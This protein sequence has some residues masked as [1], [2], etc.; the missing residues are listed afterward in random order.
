M[1]A[2]TPATALLIE[3]DIPFTLHEYE[4]EPLSG[5]Q[6]HRGERIAYGDAAASALGISPDRLYKTLVLAIEGAKD[7]RL[8]FA[9]AVVPSSGELSEKGV[10][11]ALGAKRAALADAESVRRVTGY[12]PGGVSPLGSKRALPL[13]VDSGAIAHPTILVSAGQRGQSIELVPADLLS[14]GQGMLA[15]IGVAR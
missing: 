3:H 5:V 1:G 15:P 10:A 11:A 4:L 14:V 6:Q 13:L 8:L 2:G 7:S 12:V 9:L